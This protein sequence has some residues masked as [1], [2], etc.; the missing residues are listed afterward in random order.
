MTRPTKVKKIFNELLIAF[1]NTESAS[2]LLAHASK[3]VDAVD[4]TLTDG[5]V[6]FSDGRTPLCEL[7]VHDVISRWQWELVEHDYLSAPYRD[8]EYADD[9]MAHVPDDIKWQE[10]LMA[11]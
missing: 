5:G 3:L 4:D 1:G 9:Y 11:A 2:D 6:Y 7:P 10:L 8:Q